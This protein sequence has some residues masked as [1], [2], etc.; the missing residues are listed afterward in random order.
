MRQLPK[1]IGPREWLLTKF[2]D[3]QITSWTRAAN[4]RLR[5]VD[6]TPDFC[7]TVS[8]RRNAGLHFPTLRTFKFPGCSIENAFHQRIKHCGQ[9][10]QP[11]WICP[12][13]SATFLSLAPGFIWCNA[14]NNAATLSSS[15]YR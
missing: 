14:N 8:N 10:I 15:Q 13:N 2:G 4:D 12:N 6:S 3:E 11:S 7:A 5:E 9:L 1:L